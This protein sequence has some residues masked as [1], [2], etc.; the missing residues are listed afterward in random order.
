M[1]ASSTSSAV[2]QHLGHFHRRRVLDGFGRFDGGF[3]F[4]PGLQLGTD[5]EQQ[6]GADHGLDQQLA[7]RLRQGFAEAGGPVVFD[8]QDRRGTAGGDAVGQIRS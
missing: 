4:E 5:G 8:D 2:G 6:V 7:T 3:G 1:A